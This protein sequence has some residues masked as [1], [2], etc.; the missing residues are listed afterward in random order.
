MRLGS[1]DSATKTEVPA[2][3]VTYVDDEALLLASHSAQHLVQSIPGIVKLVDQTMS[4]FGLH[5]NWGPGKSEI[6]ITLRGHKS[7]DINRRIWS[8]DTP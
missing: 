8:Q 2:P 7:H 3:E 4:E 5:T 6:M 1:V